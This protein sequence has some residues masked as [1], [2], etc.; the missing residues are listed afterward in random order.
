MMFYALVI[1]GFC[2]SVYGEIRYATMPPGEQR[3]AF[4]PPF[5]RLTA[6]LFGLLPVTLGGWYW[7]I[8]LLPLALFFGEE[9][10][11]HRLRSDKS[12]EWP[13]GPGV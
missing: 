2:V 3:D 9:R 4:Y 6:V 5:I 1:I 13:T 10:I 8:I 12:K 11:R 7:S